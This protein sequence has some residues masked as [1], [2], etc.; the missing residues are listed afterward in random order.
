MCGAIGRVCLALCGAFLCSASGFAQS[1][2]VGQF[3]PSGEIPSPWRIELI[4]P[5]LPATQYRLREWAGVGAV[6]AHA[7]KSMALLARPLDID[8]TRT[9][10]LCWRWRIDAAV[11]SAD[12]SRKSGDDYA[13][14]V[15]LSFSVAPENL[16][17]TTRLGLATA[18]ALRGPHIPDAALNY[19]WDNRHPI[20]YI[21]PNA[22]TD[23]AMMHVLRTGDREAGQ[24]LTE[25]R[26]VSTDFQAAFGHAPLRITGLAIATD[27]DNTGSEARAGFAQFRF[28]G[29]GEGC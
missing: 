6:E 1:V 2:W 28:V 26:P 23:R 5:D 11:A 3:P 12:M 20:G 4:K 29:A 27:T 14:R 13:A 19:V 15:Y 10:D 24:W 7:V 25:R 22:Y 21:R 16:S 17:L 8:L 9:P 18:R